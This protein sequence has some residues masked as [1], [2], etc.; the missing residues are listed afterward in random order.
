MSPCFWVNHYVDDDL[1]ILMGTPLRGVL[2]KHGFCVLIHVFLKP[3]I[4]YT[5]AQPHGR[6]GLELLNLHPPTDF[7]I[8]CIDP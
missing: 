1:F 3:L 4:A 5:S 7:Y 8:D 6:H 2:G